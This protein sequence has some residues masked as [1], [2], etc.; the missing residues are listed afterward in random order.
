M[1]LN[2]GE[3]TAHVY[4]SLKPYRIFSWVKHITCIRFFSLPYA[5]ERNFDNTIR[6]DVTTYNTEFHA[7]T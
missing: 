6:Y 4:M 7:M 1:S 3:Y 2:A 5:T